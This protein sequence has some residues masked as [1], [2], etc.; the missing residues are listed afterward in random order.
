MFID[1]RSLA[2]LNSESLIGLG[3]YHSAALVALGR[4][5]LCSYTMR[6]YGV[7]VLV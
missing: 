6:M 7:Y 4:D 1:A 5:V 2:S 3:P